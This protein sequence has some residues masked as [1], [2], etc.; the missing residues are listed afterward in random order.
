MI[1]DNSHIEILKIYNILIENN[2]KPIGVN[3]D[4]IL[5]ESNKNVNI[6]NLF[7]FEYGIGNYKLEYNKYPI[8]TS[9]NLRIDND[10]IELLNTTVIN[11]KINDEY[12]SIE[13]KNIFDNHNTLI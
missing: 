2:I 7:N 3:T 4:C 11:H 6:N 12:N 1:Y 10:L 5:F 13:F 9:L 8:K